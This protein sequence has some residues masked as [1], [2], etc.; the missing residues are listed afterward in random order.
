MIIFILPP[1]LRPNSNLLPGPASGGQV[2]LRPRGVE[3]G[4]RS[5]AVVIRTGV[6]DV[7]IVAAVIGRRLR[8]G[9]RSGGCRRLRP[10]YGDIRHIPHHHLYFSFH[11]FQ[12][13]GVD[14]TEGDGTLRTVQRADDGLSGSA[15]R[16]SGISLESS[17]AQAVSAP[18]PRQSRFSQHGQTE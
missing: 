12:S 6:L 8:S 10:G 4:R 3:R 13:L 18:S 11:A 2:S 7:T 17:C 15:A 16:N 14:R 9:L 5:I 1:F